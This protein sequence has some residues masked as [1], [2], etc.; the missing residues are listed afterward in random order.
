MQN[1]LSQM[2]DWLNRAVNEGKV[3]KINRP[4]TYI[5]NQSTTQLSLL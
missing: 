1:R 5:I 2:Q 4:V 3:R